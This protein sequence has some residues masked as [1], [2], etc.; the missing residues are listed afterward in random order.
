MKVF[1]YLV[2]LCFLFCNLVFAQSD[3]A[4]KAYFEAYDSIDLYD[5]SIVFNGLEYIDQYRSLNIQNH[6][7]YNSSD[8]LNG[9][10]IYNDQPFFNVKMKYDLLNDLVIL[11]FVNKKVANL[12]LNS[13]LVNQFILNN[14]KFFRLPETETLMPFYGNGFFK[15]CFKG[16]KYTLYVK[17]KKTKNKKLRNK[18]VYYTF[19]AHEIYVLFYRNMYYRINS[20][21]DIVA[22]IPDKEKEISSHYKSNK[23]LYQISESQFLIKLL[24]NLD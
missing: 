2:F 21:K 14:D 1:T 4:K 13:S 16:T 17:N 22:A 11:E 18:Q 12:S 7:F 24:S 19:K 6:K 23:R 9:F 5:N 8:Y 20:K 10:I 3:F 15:E